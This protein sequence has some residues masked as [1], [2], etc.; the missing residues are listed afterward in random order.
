VEVVGEGAGVI[1]FEEARFLFL[2]ACAATLVAADRARVRQCERNWR[3]SNRNLHPNKF[4]HPGKIKSAI[5]VD[6]C[7]IRI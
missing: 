7:L 4:G 6:H 1:V 5:R 3:S 2:E